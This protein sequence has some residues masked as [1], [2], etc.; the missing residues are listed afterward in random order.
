MV[1]RLSV[2]ASLVAACAAAGSA[3]AAT[4]EPWR[5]GFQAAASPVMERIS[6]FHTLLF[7][8]ITLIVLLVLGMLVYVMIRFNEKS[9]P[10]PSKTTHHTV[11]EVIWT[12][13]PVVILMVIAVPSF[14]LLYFMDRTQ[15]AEM[16]LKVI[17]HQWYWS[18]EYP[19]H[20]NFTF[21]SLMVPDDELKDGQ[22]RLLAVDNKVV[23]PVGTDIRILM[24]SDDVL[25]AWAVPA[26]GI[27]LDTV[28]GRIN[29]A[30]VRIDREG[31]YYGQC[32]ELCGV[33]HAYMPVA[34]EAV[35]KEAFQAWVKTAKKEFA[36]AA[37]EATQ[38]AETGTAAR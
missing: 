15:D 23:L 22:P 3:L 16:T 24:T 20:G 2:L 9:N 19:D 28:P 38:V 5:L 21:D 29:E 36:R 4:P 32:S 6:E 37:T 10:V 7:V 34:V 8:I 26:F 35:S 13:I 27:K 31:T 30:W 17:G 12:A 11:L 18:Y 1:K 25:H 33:N 14:K